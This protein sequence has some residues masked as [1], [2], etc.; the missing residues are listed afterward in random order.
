MATIQA[1]QGK[2]RAIGKE[3]SDE[4]MTDRLLSGLPSSFDAFTIIKPS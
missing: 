4:D 1:I 3:L 2:L